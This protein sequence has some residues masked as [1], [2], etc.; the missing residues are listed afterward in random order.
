MYL[1]LCN[2]IEIASYKTWRLDGLVPGLRDPPSFYLSRVLPPLTGFRQLLAPT[3]AT[4]EPIFQNGGFSFHRFG[5]RGRGWHLHFCGGIPPGG[6]GRTK[7]GSFLVKI[8]LGTLAGLRIAL[9]GIFGSA[10]LASSRN[11]VH[12]RQQILFHRLSIRM[13]TKQRKEFHGMLTSL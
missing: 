4:S 11:R 5:S 9:F 6:I 8:Q 12:T 3:A 7:G 10:I 13:L 2:F 1:C